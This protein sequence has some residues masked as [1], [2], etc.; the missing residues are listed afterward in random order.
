VRT[1]G[2]RYIS[3]PDFTTFELSRSL[4]F[5]CAAGPDGTAGA[6]ADALSSGNLP[7]AIRNRLM[8]RALTCQPQAV[9]A[10]GD[11]VYWDLHTPRIPPERHDYTRE[12][13]FNR[14]A[15]V[16]GERNETVLKLAAGPQIV[17][18]Y[19]ADFRS[20]PVFFLQDDHDYFDND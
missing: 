20:T 8:R 1:S 18:V 15:L 6:N 3:R 13:S 11:H 10:N 5:T 9:V 14:S 4:F 16:F 2:T 12:K 17:P 19:G 7:T